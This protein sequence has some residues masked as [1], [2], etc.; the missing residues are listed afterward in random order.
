[1][2]KEERKPEQSIETLF[3]QVARVRIDNYVL[4]SVIVVANPYYVPGEVSMLR[5]GF[6]FLA[7]NYLLLSKKG[8][9]IV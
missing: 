6:L 2:T 4:I 1:L 9:M 3:R 7:K 5:S 8:D